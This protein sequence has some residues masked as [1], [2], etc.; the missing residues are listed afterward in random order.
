IH[1]LKSIFPGQVPV[2]ANAAAC[3]LL[4]GFALW[5]LRKEPLPVASGWKL[6]AKV[7]ATMVGAVGM[8]SFLEFTCGWD[9]GIDQLL[10]T[11]GP[12]D[13]PGS[14]RPGLMAPI[15]AWGFLSLGPALLLLDAKTRL[16]RWAAQL[17][18]CGVA[19][20]SMFGILDFVLDPNTTHTHI[21]PVTASALFLFSFGMIFARTQP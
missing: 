3:F 2:K 6:A 13:I 16:G 8:L 20:A 4:I 10:F 17:L 14:V 19:I 12:E 11:A 18:P 21:S 7:A 1:A 9:F 15:A 5:F